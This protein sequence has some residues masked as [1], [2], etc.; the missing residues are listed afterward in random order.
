MSGRIEHSRRHGPFDSRFLPRPDRVGV[1][2]RSSTSA[3][4]N[5][6]I[7]LAE[8]AERLEDEW[9]ATLAGPELQAWEDDGGAVWRQRVAGSSS[10]FRPRRRDASESAARSLPRGRELARL[11][12]ARSALT[13]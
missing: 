12:L 3:V 1:L 7:R 8:E 2:P 9:R 10:S 6:S 4:T 5:G 13:R 11:F